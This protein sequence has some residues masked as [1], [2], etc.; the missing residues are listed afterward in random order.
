MQSGEKVGAAQQIQISLWMLLLNFFHYLLDANHY[1]NSQ[2]CR[3]WRVESQLELY[4]SL[5]LNS[6]DLRLY[7]VAK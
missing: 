4:F 5:T 2:E 3:V 6:P 1:L 7:F